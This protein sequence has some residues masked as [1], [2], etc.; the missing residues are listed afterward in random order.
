MPL[1]LTRNVLQAA[2]LAALWHDGQTYGEFDYYSHHLLGVVE[3]ALLDTKGLCKKDITI[4]ALLHDILEDT[5]C[6][7]SR[8]D[9]I[10]SRKQLEAVILLSRNFT[11]EAEY[12]PKIKADP[13]ARHIKIADANFNV[14]SCMLDGDLKR[15]MKYQDILNYLQDV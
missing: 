4:V 14:I 5:S 1:P 11:P 9:S 6:S 12:L 8:L 13:L 15:A 7:V 10:L 3:I 2:Q